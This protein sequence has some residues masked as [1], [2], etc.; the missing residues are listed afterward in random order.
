MHLNQKLIKLKVMLNIMF[1][2][3]WGRVC[4]T[5]KWI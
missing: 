3:W 5:R 2:V 4:K 1:G